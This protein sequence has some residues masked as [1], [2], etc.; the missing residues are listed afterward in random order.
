MRQ[1]E[2]QRKLVSNTLYAVMRA[3]TV[4]EAWELVVQ[5][6]NISVTK[7]MIDES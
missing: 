1:L 2:L 5:E 3:K 7:L 4:I 6:W